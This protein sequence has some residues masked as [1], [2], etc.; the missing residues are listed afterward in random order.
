MSVLGQKGTYRS[1]L[2]DRFLA[3]DLTK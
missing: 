1:V 3:I 2:A